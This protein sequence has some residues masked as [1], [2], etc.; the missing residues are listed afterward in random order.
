[1]K[2]MFVMVMVLVMLVTMSASAE[3]RYSSLRTEQTKLGVRHN[4]EIVWD[5][6]YY[7]TLSSESGSKTE[8]ELTKAEYDAAYKKLHP[9]KNF[10]QKAGAW[11]SFW[12]PND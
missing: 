12:N 5:E 1:M 6:V 2:K 4:G 3:L 11:I 9:E 7:G 8:I 10:F